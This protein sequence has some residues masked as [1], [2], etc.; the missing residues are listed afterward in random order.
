MVGGDLA[1]KKIAVLDF[2]V[3][4]AK[5][6]CAD[7]SPPPS[8]SPSAR[9]N[10]C[11]LIAHLAEPQTKTRQRA[12]VAVLEQLASM[13]SLTA[14]L[15]HLVDDDVAA[16]HVLQSLRDPVATAA[17][18]LPLRASTSGVGASDVPAGAAASVATAGLGGV[19]GAAVQPDDDGG[20][21]D[22]VEVEGLDLAAATAALSRPTITAWEQQH[23]ERVLAAPPRF[24][25]PVP[26]TAAQQ[27]QPRQPRTAAVPVPVVKSAEERRREAEKWSEAAAAF[28]RAAFA[29]PATVP[30]T[31]AHA[32][33]PVVMTAEQGQSA[34][35]APATAP[36]P[37][38]SPPQFNFAA[39]S[40]EARAAA[41]AAVAARRKAYEKSEKERK[42]K[43]AGQ[44]T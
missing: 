38:V 36:G 33:M 23:L 6:C 27:R 19:A 12:F 21:E 18:L 9:A 5:H 16:A 30:R 32:A 31:A 29:A 13:P 24:A 37:T 20:E 26:R 44:A 17:L 43:L 14:Q 39:M 25:T 41:V 10:F 35:Q 4:V 15:L 7:T 28:S 1:P 42:R 40:K 11:R 8:I 2:L 22:T 34:G 3:V